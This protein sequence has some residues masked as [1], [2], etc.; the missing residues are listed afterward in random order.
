MSRKPPDCFGI[1]SSCIRIYV[2]GPCSLSRSQFRSQCPLRTPPL[3]PTLL[4][5]PSPFAPQLPNVNFSLFLKVTLSTCL[6]RDFPR[7]YS[8]NFNFGSTFDMYQHLVYSSSQLFQ[9]IAYVYQARN[10]HFCVKHSNRFISVYFC[11][12]KF[13]ILKL[14]TRKNSH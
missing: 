11:R 2:P 14:T 12:V 10:I 5:T 7:I 8:R 13:I 1:T 4:L 6:I 9:L 3:P